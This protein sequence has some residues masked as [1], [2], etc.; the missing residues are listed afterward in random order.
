MAGTSSVASKLH[1]TIDAHFRVDSTD[2]LIISRAIARIPKGLEVIAFTVS[3][4]KL[5]TEWIEGLAAFAHEVDGAETVIALIV[6]T[7]TVLV[8]QDV[9]RLDLNRGRAK[10][11][12][13]GEEGDKGYRHGLHIGAHI[14]C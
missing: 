6:V 12:Q 7:A 1:A 4:S 8:E 5:V 11:G 14:V 3:A 2:A 10:E 9:C 13:D